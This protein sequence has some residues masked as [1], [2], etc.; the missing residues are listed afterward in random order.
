MLFDAPAARRIDETRRHKRPAKPPMQSSLQS[1]WC[2]FEG[3]P[4]FTGDKVAARQKI[5]SLAR[6]PISPP[7]LLC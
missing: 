1:G 4:S 5:A 3:E 2:L 6:L 7:R